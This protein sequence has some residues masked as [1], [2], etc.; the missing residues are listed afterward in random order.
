MLM[1]LCE[2][3]FPDNLTIAHNKNLLNDFDITDL[4]LGGSDEK[5]V[6]SNYAISKA[7]ISCKPMPGKQTLD[8]KLCKY[9]LKSLVTKLL[10]LLNRI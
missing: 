5:N 3:C 4:P 6:I 9:L 8:L 7:A 2:F 10:F 1:Q